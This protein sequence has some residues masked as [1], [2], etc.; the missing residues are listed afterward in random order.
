MAEYWDAFLSDHKNSVCFEWSLNK[1]LEKYTKW[2][3]QQPD[4]IDMLKYIRGKQEQE[5]ANYNTVDGV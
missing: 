5:L 2:L 4:S 1:L 3:A